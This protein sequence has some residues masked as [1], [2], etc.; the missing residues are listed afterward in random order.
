MIGKIV[1]KVLRA[2]SMLFPII[3]VDVSSDGRS[4]E[5]RIK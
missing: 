3:F 1:N 4:F 2:N 5:K